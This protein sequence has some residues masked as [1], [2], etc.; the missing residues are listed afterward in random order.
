MWGGGNCAL[1]SLAKPSLEDGARA[2]GG[3]ATRFLEQGVQ[4][5]VL[6]IMALHLSPGA[7]WP[8]RHPGHMQVIQIPRPCVCLAGALFSHPWKGKTEKVLS[9]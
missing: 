3:L 7:G 8:P 2:S 5:S 4:T 1:I 9:P 6:G